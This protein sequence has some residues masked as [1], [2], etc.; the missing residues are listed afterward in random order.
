MSY[1]KTTINAI[2][3]DI[4]ENKVYL[5]ALQRKFVWGKYKIE[6]LFDSLMRNFPIGTFLF[7]KLGRQKAETYVFYEFLKEYNEKSPYNRRKT[8]AFLNEE[9]IGVLDGQQRLS[10]IYIGLM[11]THTERIKYGWVNNP[12]A[13]EKTCLYLN[14]LSLPYIITAENKINQIEDKNFE[15]RFLPPQKALSS[16]E[17]KVGGENGTPSWMEP[18]FW[19]KVGD[20]LSWGEDPEFDQIMEEFLQQ[21]RSDVQREAI[22]RQKRIIRK[23]LDTLHERMYH[24]ELINY[25]EVTKDE[26]EDILKIFVRV[27]SGG[28]PLSKPDLLF[29]TIVATW[30][31]GREQIENLLRKIN[32]KGDG[33]NF[34]NEYLMRCCLV[35]SDGPAI[36]K[37]NS[38][39][40]ENV[41]NIKAQWPQIAAAIEKTVDLL[42]EFGFAGS[43]LTSQNATILIAYYLMKGGD[44]SEKSKND[45]RKY[46]V[47]A[48]LN[49]IFGS[50]QDQLIIALRNAFREEIKGVTGSVA[51]RGRYRSFSF[52]EVLKIHLPQQK[53]LSI[54]EEDI[55]R[56]LEYKKGYGSFWMLT[57]LYPQLRYSEVVFHQDHIHPAASFTKEKF[58]EMGIPVE[59]WQEWWDCRDC[60]PNLQL[61]EGRRNESK[62][63]TPFKTWF[64]LLD[65]TKQ[66]AFADA[67]YLPDGVGLE[68]ENFLN[69]FHSRKDKL[70]R[71]LK[72][73]LALTT[74]SPA[75]GVMD[76]TDPEDEIETTDAQMAGEQLNGRDLSNA[77]AIPD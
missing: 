34:G 73:V 70:R 52:E 24:D 20:V 46:L 37:V 35:L 21:T 22:S 3:K 23:A 47:H 60:L 32:A 39:K 53:T 75:V 50:A 59:Q 8:G 68:F 40:S 62:N 38:F 54:T 66:A 58:K 48:L 16:T 17:R 76:W 15:F 36:Y 5:P 45:M 42:V 33:F 30:D 64:G 29:S 63:A 74:E 26:L 2:I 25:F 13:Y 51:Y 69:F 72:K 28:V 11:G 61:M 12:N 56:F 57:L 67:N 49:G 9:I 77:V 41:E 71:E 18:M 4:D 14:L 1:Q 27:N 7:W 44:Q 43:V 19:M 6:L 10:S 65:D 31:D 55:E